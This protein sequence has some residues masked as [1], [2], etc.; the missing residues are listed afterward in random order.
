M[1]RKLLVSVACSTTVLLTFLP[2]GDHRFWLGVLTCLAVLMLGALLGKE[3]RTK[4]Q[5]VG[6]QA[7]DSFLADAAAAR[8]IQART[9][10]PQQALRLSTRDD[11]H[12][13]EI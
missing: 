5:K 2:E 4:A 13:D 3:E 11:E 12:S 1:M 9:Q 10:A 8:D 7:I 6:D